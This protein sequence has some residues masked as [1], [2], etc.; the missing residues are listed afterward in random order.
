MD[1]CLALHFTQ[2][3]TQ[4]RY[5]HQLYFPMLGCLIPPLILSI[6]VIFQSFSDHKNTHLRKNACND[7][8]FIRNV[9]MWK[10]IDR[11]C[12]YLAAG[13]CSMKKTCLWTDRCQLG[14]SYRN[15][16]VQCWNLLEIIVFRETEFRLIYCMKYGLSLML[17]FFRNPSFWNPISET[18]FRF[19]FGHVF[20]TDS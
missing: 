2:I 5:L 8:N 18:R 6:T 13:K 20:H 1:S 17:I 19:I 15:I 10:S 3:I 14:F 4:T 7:C 16:K 9:Q 12:G 11:N